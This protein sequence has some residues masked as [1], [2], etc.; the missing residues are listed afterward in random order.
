MNSIKNKTMSVDLVD[1]VETPI[2]KTEMII[3][4]LVVDGTTIMVTTTATAMVDGTIIMVTTATAMGMDTAEDTAT[5][6]T[7]TVLEMG[8]VAEDLETPTTDKDFGC[9]MPKTYILKELL[10]LLGNFLYWLY[11]SYQKDL[12]KT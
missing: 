3:M 6:T 5:V 8:M 11:L 12:Y 2:T 7:A 4:V 1:M 9:H 10:L